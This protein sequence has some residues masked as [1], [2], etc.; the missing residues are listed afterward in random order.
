MT[1]AIRTMTDPRTGDCV[2]CCRHSS[3]M[4]IR[5]AEM[6]GFHT[7]AAQLGVRFG[8]V[9]TR[10]RCGSAVH[11]LP[12]GTAHYLEHRLFESEDGSVSTAMSALGAADN[13]YTEFDRTVYYFRT[14]GGIEAPLSLLLKCV[15]TPY[16]PQA[17]I[18]RERPII[19]QEIQEYRDDPDDRLFFQMLEGLY[20]GLPLST[21]VG[22]TAESIMQ[23]TPEM[24]YT[25]HRAFYRPENMVLCCAGNLT[26]EQV[27]E[28]ADRLLRH[29]QLPETVL[30]PPEQSRLPQRRRKSC[31]MPVGKPML[32]LGFRSEPAQGRERLRDALLCELGLSALLSAA[33][34]FYAYLRERGLVTEPLCA[35]TFTGSGWFCVTA[36]GE[37][38]HPEQV[39]D[40]LLAELARAARE[41][42]DPALFDEQRRGCYKDALLSVSQ[43]EGFADALTDTALLGGLSPFERL[44]LLAALT[45]EDAAECL[46]RRTDPQQSCL[47]AVLPDA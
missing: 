40:A 13:A 30:L 22:G 43:P 44:H 4:E 34:P 47:S 21:D 39:R 17:G 6:Q 31:R 5:V 25:A 20:P 46:C 11:T 37:S 10:F 33:S 42:I 41:G 24:L 18:D 28:T 38:P 35:D 2:R 16:F 27:L 15:Q 19:L 1:E 14:G 36:E 9:H 32:M 45:A 26:A 3:G 12:A 7:A 23:I 29:P 8:S